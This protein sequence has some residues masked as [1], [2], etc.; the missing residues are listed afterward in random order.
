MGSVEGIEVGATVV[1]TVGAVVIFSVG[2]RVVVGAVVVGLRVVVTAAGVLFW[3]AVVECA[4]CFVVVTGTAETDETAASDAS[5][6]ERTG[7]DAV[8]FSSI[9]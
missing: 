1:G 3:R 6:P 4:V 8:G 9:L 2:L 5:S 7:S